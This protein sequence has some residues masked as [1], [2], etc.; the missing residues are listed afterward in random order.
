[1][2]FF[3]P[4][5]ICPLLQDSEVIKGLVLIAVEYDPNIQNVEKLKIEINLTD[6]Q[7]F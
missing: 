5:S 6:F 3:Q 4:K 7:N 1:M 2:L